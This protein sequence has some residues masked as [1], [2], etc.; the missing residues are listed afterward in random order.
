MHSFSGGVL[1]LAQED[2]FNEFD[3]KLKEILLEEIASISELL[4]L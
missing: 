2:F 3:G 4:E 1:S